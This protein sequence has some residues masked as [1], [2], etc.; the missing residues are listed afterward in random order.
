MAEDI[1]LLALETLL[2]AE[3]QNLF[4]KDALH[5][6]LTMKQ[7]LSKQDRAF[8]TRLVSGVTEY[9]IRL[10]HIL[11]SFSRTRMEKCKPV[12]RNLLRMGAYQLAF[13][14]SIPAAAACSES[15]RLAKKKGFGNLSGFVNGVL[16]STARGLDTVE[17]PQNEREY[18]SIWYSVPQWLT[19]SLIKWYGMERTKAYLEASIKPSGLTIRVNTAHV[20]PEELTERLVSSGVEVSP[21]RYVRDALRLSNINYVNRLPG[22]REGDFFVQDESSMLV[23]ELAG[24]EREHWEG[25]LRVIDLCAAP[26]GKCTHFAQ[27]LGD[28]VQILAGD[29]T[30]RKVS[31]IRENM[32][33]LHLTQIE[34]QSWDAREIHPDLMEWADVVIADLPCSGLGILSKKSDIKYHM[35]SSQLAELAALQRQILG[36]AASYVRPGGILLYSTC[37]V[38]PSENADNA[39]WFTGQYPF[40]ADPVMDFVPEELRQYVEDGNM[41][42]LVPGEAECD[43]F[44]IARF[45]KI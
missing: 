41:L 6:T 7:F 40:A 5:R 38:N 16:R 43:G 3:K 35:G 17:Y 4:V 12:I 29:L 15:V 23:Y 34:V 10:D 2:E 24:L 27:K 1:R 26:G 42:K 11:N 8:L 45:R 36:T 14:D 9:R 37:T 28:R 32:E 25:K 31:L 13:M 18:L 39:R 22:F 30:E 44:F 20:T 21:G 33:R 19:D